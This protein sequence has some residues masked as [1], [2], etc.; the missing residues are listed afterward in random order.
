MNSTYLEFDDN[1]IIAETFFGEKA[2]NH[3][4]NPPENLQI[5]AVQRNGILL[6]YLDNPT[7]NV[8]LAA[9]RQNGMALRFI[10]EPSQKV[11]LEAV[12]NNPSA[13]IFI[14]D[15]NLEITK[16]VA[17]KLELQDQSNIFE[18]VQLKAIKENP[19]N[20]IFMTNPSLKVQT[21][22]AHMLEFRITERENPL[23]LVQLKAI[24]TQSFFKEEI[25]TLEDI[26][27]PDQSVID[28]LKWEKAFEKERKEYENFAMETK[29]KMLKLDGW[30]IKHYSHPTMEMMLVAV[31]NTG[32]AIKFIDEPPIKV[33][34]AAV[35]DTT[36]AIK[37]INNPSQ[38]AIE[39]AAEKMGLPLSSPNLLEKIHL[40]IISKDPWAIENLPEANESLQLSAVVKEDTTVRFIKN[41]SEKIQMTAII[42]NINNLKYIQHPTDN[43]VAFAVKK[44]LKAAAFLYCRGQMNNSKLEE[45]ITEKIAQALPDEE[46]IREFIK[47]ETIIGDK[48][49]FINRFASSSVKKL[50]LDIQLS[51]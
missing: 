6:K 16:I 47:T 14:A 34:V 37:Y 45:I 7:E 26:K 33:Q 48:L 25:Y 11:Q 46:Y 42:K 24:K 43:V 38:E 50:V 36:S 18:T 20:L 10:K 35:N 2:I 41:P 28:V 19:Y 1:R 23:R 49:A 12:K 5:S 22:A 32:S 21:M 4:Q 44:S 40:Q 9:M 17:N 51:L 30:A 15:P 29:L 27:N 39:T 13:L 8:Q 31:K 3:F